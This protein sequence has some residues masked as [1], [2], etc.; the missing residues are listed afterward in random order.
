LISDK[1]A[2]KLKILIEQPGEG[3]WRFRDEPAK[4]R[5]GSE[6]LANWI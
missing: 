1:L 4:K 6:P 2:G 5:R 3:I